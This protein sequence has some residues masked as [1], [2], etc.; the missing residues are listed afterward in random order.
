MK[1]GFTTAKCA[2]FDECRAPYEQSG[3]RFAQ[4][5]DWPESV[6]QKTL[7]APSACCTSTAIPASI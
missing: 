6:L 3:F 5:P 4:K 7:L 1:D 2:P